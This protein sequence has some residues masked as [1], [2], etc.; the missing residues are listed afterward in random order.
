MGD[1]IDIPVVT[2]NEEI[3]AIKLNANG[4]FLIVFGFF[5]FYGIYKIIFECSFQSLRWKENRHTDH[6]P[7]INAECV[8]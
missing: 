1:S 4:W 3:N 8:V 6:V 5:T 2:T 7:L